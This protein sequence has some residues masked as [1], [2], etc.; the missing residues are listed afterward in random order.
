MTNGRRLFTEKGCL[1]CHSHDGTTQS[2]PNVGVAYGEANFAPNLSRIAA[3]IAPGGGSF[4]YSTYF[5][6]NG[7]DFSNGSTIDSNGNFYIY[8]DTSSTSFPVLNAFQPTFC[9]WSQGQ[10]VTLNHGWVG[11]L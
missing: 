9:G 4:V 2:S 5:G 11:M 3:K 6:G 8:G 10:T 1:A 7:G